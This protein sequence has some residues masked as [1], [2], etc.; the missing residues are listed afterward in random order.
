MPR[1]TVKKAGLGLAGPAR[2]MN[3]KNRSQIANGGLRF[4]IAWPA[5]CT[6]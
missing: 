3:A 1:A 4:A 2:A 6:G 5:C